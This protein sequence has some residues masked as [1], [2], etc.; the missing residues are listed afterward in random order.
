MIRDGDITPNILCQLEIL[1]NTLVQRDAVFE[2]N[3]PQCT[4]NLASVSLQ[5]KK[6][7]RKRKAPPLYLV[8]AILEG[9][10]LGGR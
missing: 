9:Q 8:A 6:K 1:K 10:D 4:V 3:R 2:E 7:G 5:R